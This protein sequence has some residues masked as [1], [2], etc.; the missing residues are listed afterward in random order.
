[1]PEG[2]TIHYAANRIRPVLAGRVP[3]LILTPSARH[4]TGPGIAS[5]ADRL[6]GRSVRSVDALGKHLFL[7]FDGDLTVHSHLRMTGSWGVYDGHAPWRR[8]R[9]RAWLE[10][11]AGRDVVVQF[12]GPVLELVRDSRTRFDQQLAGLGQ[13]VLG[14]EFD[15]TR[16]LGRLREDDPTRPV[17]DALLDQRTLAGIGNIWKAESCFAAALDPWRP[18]GR[19]TD[20][21]VL[22]AVRFARE[23]MAQSARDGF[24]ARPRAVYGRRGEACGRCGGRIR[25]AGQGEQNRNTFWCPG[26]QR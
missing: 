17:G 7:R 9:H 16:F 4:R 3:E 10:I 23:R 20:A 5:W 11:H 13:D 21:E 24:E 12:D 22:A 1:M 14:D 15:E 2:D 6:A 25:S 19:T 18:V 8:A 26:C